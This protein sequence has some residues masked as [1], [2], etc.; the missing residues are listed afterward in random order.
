[1]KQKILKIVSQIK[2]DLKS[3]DKDG[4]FHPLYDSIFEKL[5]LIEDEIY[6]DDAQNDSLSFEDDDY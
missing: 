1:M 3:I 6:E 5:E 4:V 2:D